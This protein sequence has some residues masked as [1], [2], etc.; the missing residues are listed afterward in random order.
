MTA[1]RSCR[2]A[3][4]GRR[5]KFPRGVAMKGRK[6]FDIRK[7]SREQKNGSSLGTTCLVAEKAPHICYSPQSS[8]GGEQ[9]EQ[10][11]HPFGRRYRV[12]GTTLITLPQ[13][14]NFKAL[15]APRSLRCHKRSTS[16]PRLTSPLQLALRW[17][18]IASF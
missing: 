12:G 8:P 16:K 3:S 15:A 11:S 2:N 1:I 14:I 4:S 10:R 17:L 5:R 18:P 13:A 7:T 6:N 9:R